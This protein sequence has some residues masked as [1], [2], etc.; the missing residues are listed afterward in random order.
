MA[1]KKILFIGG[2]GQISLRCVETAVAAGHQ[3]SVFNRGETAA[4]LPGGVELIA[5]RFEDDAS[6][7]ALARR[8]FD[9][10]CQFIAYVPE[11]VQRD[12]KMFRGRTGQYVFISTA[13]AYQKPVVHYRVTERVPLVNPFWEY[14]RRKAACEL[15]LRGQGDVPYTI[16]RPSHTVRTRVPAAFGEGDQMASRMQAGLPVVVPGDGTSL[17]PIMR[18][19]DF[20]PP[21][22]K[23]LGEPR[24]LGEDFHIASDCA[25]T[26]NQIY[27]AIGHG[28]G[29]EAELVHVPTD[30][31]VKIEPEW[32]GPLLGDKIYS[33]LF[34]NSKVKAIVG[35]FACEPDI[36]RVV[37]APC[38]A[39][40]ARRAALGPVARPFDAAFERAIAGQRAVGG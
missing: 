32:T 40:L 36:D 15:L 16:V 13:S 25:F 20:A 31:L 21:F 8:E 33:V 28:I 39:Y 27:Q 19:D 1:M 38:A 3:V 5:G 34:D 24:A 2:T 35:D 7:A 37:A 12:L 4:A 23:L 30:T 9:T 26:W 22:V 18:V 11:Q 29:A 10:V 17:W 6:Y 14:S